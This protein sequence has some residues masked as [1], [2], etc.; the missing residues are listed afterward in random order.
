[1]TNDTNI[2]NLKVAHIYI[3]IIYVSKN[4]IPNYFVRRYMAAILPI[5]R[6]T[7]SI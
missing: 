2:S 5:Q 6:K 1:M 3:A 7:L 4:V